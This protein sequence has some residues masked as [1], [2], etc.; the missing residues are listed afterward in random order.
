ML[1]FDIQTI[2][3]CMSVCMYVFIVHEITIAMSVAYTVSEMS[4]FY[5]IGHSKVTQGH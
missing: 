5:E 2:K 1:Y 4:S 3:V